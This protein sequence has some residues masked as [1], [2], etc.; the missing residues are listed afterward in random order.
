MAVQFLSLKTNNRVVCGDVELLI[1]AVILQA[2]VTS[3]GRICYSTLFAHEQHSAEGGG[4]AKALSG[5]EAIVY[6]RCE[7][8][9]Q[10]NKGFYIPGYCWGGPSVFVV[11]LL[12]V[13][14][15]LR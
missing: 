15:F 5:A 14:S 12:L 2:S 3:D 6:R 9:P 8:I 4:S 1:G 7:L 13:I 10:N 11:A